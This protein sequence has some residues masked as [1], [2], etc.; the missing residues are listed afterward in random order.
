MKPNEA[1]GKQKPRA[2]LS[3]GDNAVIVHLFDA[4]V[5]EDLMFNMPFFERRSIKHTDLKGL[6]DR[7][8]KMAE[9]FRVDSVV[10]L[11][12]F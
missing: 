6:A 5:L 12:S 10:G 11:R 4:G 8:A 2:I 3:G 7:M 1:L 9:R